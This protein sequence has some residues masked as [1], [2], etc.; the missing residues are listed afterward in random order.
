MSQHRVQHIGWRLGELRERSTGVEGLRPASQG[1][2]SF[3]CL[4]CPNFLD[5]IHLIP[6]T[7]SFAVSCC[8]SLHFVD[9][10]LT[11]LTRL[12]ALIIS[13]V[14]EITAVL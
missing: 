5:L 10:V 4:V 8:M 6:V 13:N 12:T 9:L 14:S 7:N 11:I 1:L 3:G 2:W